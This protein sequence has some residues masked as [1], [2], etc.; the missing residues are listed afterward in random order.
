MAYVKYVNPELDLTDASTG[1][2][3]KPQRERKPPP[4]GTWYEALDRRTI[5]QAIMTQLLSEIADEII[6]SEAKLA[7]RKG[8]TIVKEG[9]LTSLYE[10]GK[11]PLLRALIQDPERAFNT[12]RNKLFVVENDDDPSVTQ[13]FGSINLVVF[14]N[15]MAIGKEP[16]DP[17]E[18][19][20]R[21]VIRAGRSG[22][23]AKDRNFAGCK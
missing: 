15:A 19:A 12:R 2:P 3:S 16:V 18:V 9:T 22:N 10:K 13:P 14:R 4:P 5:R 11:L 20:K 23:Y 8:G 21:V 7:V 17:D 1:D 6:K